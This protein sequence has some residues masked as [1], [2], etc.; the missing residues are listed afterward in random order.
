MVSVRNY[1]RDM[2][3]HHHDPGPKVDRSVGGF[4]WWRSRAAMEMDGVAMGGMAEL[5]GAARAQDS[6]A[7]LPT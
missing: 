1:I 6:D 5:T 2:P 3:D 4:K 7:N